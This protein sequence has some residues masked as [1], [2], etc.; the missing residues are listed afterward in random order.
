MRLGVSSRRSPGAIGTPSCSRVQSRT[1]LRGV[2]LSPLP[3]NGVPFGH[4]AD[5]ARLSTRWS[6]STAAPS[7]P[8]SSAST[9][10]AELAVEWGHGHLITSASSGCYEHDKAD[11]R[12]PAEALNAWR[13]HPPRG[14]LQ[15][16][17]AERMGV[18]AMDEPRSF[19][20]RCP[21]PNGIIARSAPA[22]AGAVGHAEEKQGKRRRPRRQRSIPSEWREET[23]SRFPG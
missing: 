10:T 14:Q 3:A 4:G 12:A 5:T 11:E 17:M 8:S 20:P 1:L 13:D 19:L 9:G 15:A 21:G 23:D 16:G 18:L 22:A 2:E 6:A 7:T